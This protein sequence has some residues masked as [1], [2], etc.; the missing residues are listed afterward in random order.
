MGGFFFGAYP[1]TNPFTKT[2]LSVAD[3][4]KLLMSRGLRVDDETLATHYL[5]QI[6]YYRLSGYAVPFQ[7][8]GDG[9]DHHKFRAGANFDA[10][11]DRYIFDRK[12][13][14]LIMDAVERIEISIRSG[15]SNSIAMRHGPHWYLDSNLF[16]RRFNHQKFIDD[17]KRQI[18]HDP[19]G[20]ARR[21]I[22]I[23]HYYANYNSPTMPPCWMIFESISFNTISLAFKNVIYPEFKP[24]CDA[25]NL[26]HIVL[27]SWLHAISYVRNIC[28]HHSRLWN[29]ICTI[30]PLVA[31]SY[32]S[33]LAIND[34]VYAQ[35]VVMQ[36]LLAKI[37]PG[38]HWAVKLRD[39]LDEHPNV[40]LL[41]MGFPSDWK[42]RTIWAFP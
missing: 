30:K 1:L 6:G 17:I 21:D 42:S 19:H 41:N 3:Q 39:L 35:L 9:P 12:L 5:E 32:R 37:A 20:S 15:L 22:Y 26:N 24:I 13:R 2:G 27:S 34:R 18:G 23:K 33:D 28:A 31:N 4:L 25:Y 16:D 11:I 7:L 38:N 29:R 40:P 14:L 10:I 8:G 36:I